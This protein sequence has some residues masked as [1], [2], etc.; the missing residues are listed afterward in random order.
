VDH[1]NMQHQKSL[2]EQSI[3]VIFFLKKKWKLLN[4]TKN[5]KNQ[6]GP[7]VDVWSLGVILFAALTGKLPF[8]GRTVESTYSKVLLFST[9]FYFSFL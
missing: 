4:E 7:S 9:F 3:L 6:I 1:Q 5:K 2:L 8:N